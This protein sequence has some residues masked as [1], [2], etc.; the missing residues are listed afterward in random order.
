MGQESR[1]TCG[2]AFHFMVVTLVLLAGGA[3]LGVGLWRNSRETGGPFDLQYG[4]VQNLNTVWRIALRIN[5]AAII[6]GAF[7][8][9][10]G[11]T[12]IIGASRKCLGGLFRVVYILMAIIIFI[13]LAAVSALAFYLLTQKDDGALKNFVHDAWEAT[14]SDNPNDIC[15]LEKEYKCRGFDNDDCQ[16]CSNTNQDNC[17]AASKAVCAPCGSNQ[18]TATGCWGKFTDSY[19]KYYIAVGAVFATLGGL[20]FLDM[21]VIC[22]L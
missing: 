2:T 8:L 4:D 13:G 11:I 16:K 14:V 5:T 15:K 6:V 20:V 1:N 18:F 21:F 12:A 3:L 10:A 22:G 19:R 9:V 7:M 17:T